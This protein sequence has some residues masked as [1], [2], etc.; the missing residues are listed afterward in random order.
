VTETI[1]A[2]GLTALSLPWLTPVTGLTDTLGSRAIVGFV[3]GVAIAGCA[4]LVRALDWSGFGA[5]IVCAVACTAAG[6]MWA[7]TLVGY[8]ATTSL[9]SGVGRERKVRRTSSVVAKGGE[10]DAVQV[11]ANGGI[12][13]ITAVLTLLWPG[14]VW[15]WGGLGALAASAADSWATE[16]GVLWGGAPVS[17]LRRGTVPAG[18]SGGVTLA[19]TGGAVLGASVIALIALA[20]GFPPGA[21]LAALA[22]GFTGALA[23]SLLGATVQT[24]RHCDTCGT[25][26]ER[27]VHTCG[28]ETRYLSGARWMDNDLVN[29]LATLI[30]FMLGVALFFGAVSVPIRNAGG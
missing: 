6:W 30:G 8:F 24:V 12:Y 27:I 13:S 29:L 20:A 28:S 1:S 3:L 19:G 2:A 15:A 16:I 25:D 5:A 11:L 7:I 21:P 22:S 18:T 17:L 4:R 23:D 26:T 14:N 10:R 9:V